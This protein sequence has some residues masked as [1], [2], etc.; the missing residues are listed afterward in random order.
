[1]VLGSILEC[2]P[3]DAP[4][5]SVGKWQA[6]SSLI[7][8]SAKQVDI[9]GDLNIRGQESN[10]RKIGHTNLRQPQTDH[11]LWT[12]KGTVEIPSSFTSPSCRWGRIFPW[13]T[14]I[15][16]CDWSSI[17]SLIQIGYRGAKRFKLFYQQYALKIQV[18][19]DSFINMRIVNLYLIDMVTRLLIDWMMSLTLR[20]KWIPCT[21]NTTMDFE[22][23]DYMR[24]LKRF[25]LFFFSFGWNKELVKQLKKKW[26]K[27]YCCSINNSSNVGESLCLHLNCFI[28]YC[29]KIDE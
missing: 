20:I 25:L 5:R 16:L 8:K 6:L 24:A 22:V 18:Q 7:H 28:Q 19:T 9:Y 27:Y 3:W 10:N 14:M 15:F 11:N 23:L 2:L 1:M 4:L 21:W 26:P 12:G 13:L 17:S 29:R